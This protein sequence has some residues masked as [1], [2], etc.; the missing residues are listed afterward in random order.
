[1]AQASLRPWEMI[2]AQIYTITA[3]RRTTNMRVCFVVV[4]ALRLKRLSI[5]PP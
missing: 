4:A 3:L 2:D 5:S 1:M